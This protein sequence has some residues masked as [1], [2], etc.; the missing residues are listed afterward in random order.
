MREMIMSNLDV[1]ICFLVLGC[2]LGMSMVFGY[3]LYQSRKTIKEKGF[4][5]LN[6]PKV[7]IDREMLNNNRTDYSTEDFK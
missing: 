1:F 2:I 5:I 4:G 6:E 7:Q 3:Y